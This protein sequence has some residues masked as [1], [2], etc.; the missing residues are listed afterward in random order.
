MSFFL[1]Y[2]PKFLIIQSNHLIGIQTHASKWHK[3]VANRIL[4]YYVWDSFLN[5]R[6]TSFLSM[7]CCFGN[8]YKM[9]QNYEQCKK[10]KNK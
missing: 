1:G 10:N 2:L 9:K 8:V 4:Y 3:L 7:H 6:K 5:M